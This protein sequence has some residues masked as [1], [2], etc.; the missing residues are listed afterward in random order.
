MTDSLPSQMLK[1]A[2]S[3]LEGFNGVKTEIDF[4]MAKVHEALDR[5]RFLIRSNSLNEENPDGLLI[6][7]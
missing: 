1:Q 2:E 3:K 6:S 7:D 5:L 4:Y